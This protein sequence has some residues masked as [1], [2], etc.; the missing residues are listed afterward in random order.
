[1]STIA[2]SKQPTLNKDLQAT[3]Y[4]IQHTLAKNPFSFT[5]TLDAVDI[6]LG[7]YVSQYSIREDDLL[8][9]STQRR[10]RLHTWFVWQEFLIKFTSHQDITL[11]LTIL[12]AISPSISIKQY[13]DVFTIFIDNT[14]THTL[15]TQVFEKNLPNKKH[16]LTIIIDDVGENYTLLKNFVALPIQLTFAIWPF[17]SAT[18]LSSQYLSSMKQSTI[19]HFP[20]E[21]LGFPAVEPGNGVLTLDM[22]PEIIKSQINKAL[23]AVPHAIGVNNHMGSAFTANQKQVENFIQSVAMLNPKLFI[24][25]SLTHPRSLLYS[26]AKRYNLKAFSRTIFIDNIR[27][28]EATLEQLIKAQRIAKQYGK[29][30]AIGH[31]APTT[32]EALKQFITIKNQSLD[33]IPLEKYNTYQ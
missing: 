13:G 12:R 19:I 27:T 11:L 28:V 5:Q 22:P 29:I 7:L 10:K 23:L 15:H 31:L 4:A 2:F 32:L 14:P 17:A 16:S 33:I 8:F 20:M 1:M 24:L 3:L 9:I 21:P 25:D 30:I 18:K 26:T 6:I